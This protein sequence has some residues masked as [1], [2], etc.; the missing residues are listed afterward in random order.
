MSFQVPRVY[1]PPLSFAT[2][3]YRCHSV[4]PGPPGQKRGAGFNN[5]VLA[6]GRCC[7]FFSFPPL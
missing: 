1:P 2:M 3:A 7:V 4:V 6:P 5:S